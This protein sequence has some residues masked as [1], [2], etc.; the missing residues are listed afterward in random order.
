[1]NN[2]KSVIIKTTLSRNALTRKAKYF[3]IAAIFFA[4][5]SVCSAQEG[6]GGTD[7]GNPDDVNV[8]FDGG[9]SILVAAGIGYGARKAYT[10]KKK[11]ATAIVEEE[12][13]M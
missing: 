12:A 5:S 10:A 8:P 6:P 1:M 9:V 3:F 2:T 4:F 7:V 13:A 11:N